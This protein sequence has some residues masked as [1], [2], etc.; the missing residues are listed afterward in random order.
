MDLTDLQA[1]HEEVTEFWKDFYTAFAENDIEYFL[2]T[3]VLTKEGCAPRDA[4]IRW[5]AARG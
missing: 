1:E 5:T 2:G 4:I 3:I